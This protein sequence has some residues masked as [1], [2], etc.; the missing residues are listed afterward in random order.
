MKKILEILVVFALGF[1]ASAQTGKIYAGDCS[2]FNFVGD[3]GGPFSAGVASNK[4]AFKL[5]NVSDDNYKFHFR[6]VLDNGAI[7]I[8]VISKSGIG[9]E[10]NFSTNDPDLFQV[11]TWSIQVVKPG[12]IFLCDLD[13]YLVTGPYCGPVFASQTGRDDSTAGG[14]CYYSPDGGCIDSTH[15]VLITSTVYSSD[16]S[17]YPDNIIQNLIPGGSKN[18]SSPDGILESNFGALDA[19]NYSVKIQTGLITG[20]L[21]T[22]DFEVMGSCEG[23]EDQC[24]EEPEPISEGPDV[25]SLCDQIPKENVEQRTACMDCTEGTEE[26]EEDAGVW[27]A[28]GCI[29][30]DPQIIIKKL[31]TVSLQV[32]G[33]FTLITFLVAGFIFSTSQ[34]SPERVKS[35][36]EMMT[37]SVMG[38]IFVIFSV[39]VLQFIGW[40]VL[41]IPGFGS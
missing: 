33:G 17:P 24:M 36:K 29:K 13:T 26:E 9:G 16:G 38:L 27:T 25:F 6:S 4:I 23:V 40:S 30:R 19:K 12:T 3:A 35:A 2:G 7:V 21:C 20:V 22:Y 11:G 39:S 15:D 41:K 5:T 8:K 31:I 1:F 34:G 32:G 37:A 28:I 10:L 18:G 14:V